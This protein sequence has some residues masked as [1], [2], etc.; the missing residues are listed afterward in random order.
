[1][2]ETRLSSRHDSRESA[3]ISDNVADHYCYSSN[4]TGLAYQFAIC[5]RSWE[6]F[7]NKTG[8]KRG[9]RWLNNTNISLTSKSTIL[10]LGLVFSSIKPRRKALEEDVYRGASVFLAKFRPKAQPIG[11]TLVNVEVSRTDYSKKPADSPLSSQPFI[12]RVTRRYANDF[13]QMLGIPK[14]RKLGSRIRAWRL[15]SSGLRLRSPP[16]LKISLN[17]GWISVADWA[18]LIRKTNAMPQWTQSRRNRLKDLASSKLLFPSN[19]KLAVFSKLVGGL[20]LNRQ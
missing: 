8:R 15:F 20:K 17:C 6:A 9:N 4:G 12:S 18:S 13:A 14:I 2:A 7:E 10:S 3:V 5:S 19:K 1:M 16:P 11:A